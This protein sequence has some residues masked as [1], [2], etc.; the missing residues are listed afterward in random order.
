MHTLE[1]TFPGPYTDYTHAM[2]TAYPPRLIKYALKAKKERN[3]ATAATTAMVKGEYGRFPKSFML[4]YAGPGEDFLSQRF[5]FREDTEDKEI[6]YAITYFKGPGTCSLMIYSSKGHAPPVLAISGTEKRFGSSVV[7]TAPPPPSA[8]AGTASSTVNV[9][10]SFRGK[11]HGF[12]I[13][14]PGGARKLSWNEN[15]SEKEKNESGE[16]SSNEGDRNDVF[17]WREDGAVKPKIRR[18]FRMPHVSGGTEE[19]IA[20]WK[21]GTVPNREGRLAVFEFASDDAK[22]RLGDYGALVAI[23]AVLAI[24]GIMGAGIEGAA[25][26]QQE[27]A[28]EKGYHDGYWQDQI[29]NVPQ[30]GIAPSGSNAT[31]WDYGPGR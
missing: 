10:Y 7:V 27:K 18:L 15:G 21:E 13:P 14:T 6:M 29:G 4:Y 19:L 30:G 23:S 31:F 26:W 12:T 17:E 3:A 5:Y 9:K 11:L 24:C 2:S 25:S 20:M 16:S 22:R 1:T 8:A 28:L